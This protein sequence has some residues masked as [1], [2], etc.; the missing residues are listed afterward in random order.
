MAVYVDDFHA[1]ALGAF[2][3]MKMSH[4]IADTRSEL[5]AMADRVG[6]NRRWIQ[7][8]GTHREHYDICKAKRAM[9][10]ACGA[11]EISSRETALKCRAKKEY[12]L[13]MDAPSRGQGEG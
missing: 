1:T 5:D 2:G 11:I 4:M 7:H 8:P 12:G 3:R 9:A 13:R 10:I 6:L